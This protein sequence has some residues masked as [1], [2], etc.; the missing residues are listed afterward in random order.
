[1]IKCSCYRRTMTKCAREK[2][3][4]KTLRSV[5][6][7]DSHSFLHNEE[8]S[9]GERGKGKGKKGSPSTCVSVLE[10][11][12]W[13]NHTPCYLLIIGQWSLIMT[14][15]LQ[16]TVFHWTSFVGTNIWH[17][18]SVQL[19]ATAHLQTRS[20]LSILCCVCACRLIGNHRLL[21]D[22][23]RSNR[24]SMSMNMCS[25]ECSCDKLGRT[26]DRV[27]AASLVIVEVV[28]SG[29]STNRKAYIQVTRCNLWAKY[30]V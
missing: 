26:V 20:K 29:Q 25:S 18:S 9:K 28:V 17:V 27:M 22:K 2:V 15:I 4:A 24:K 14:H 11:A 12:E 10:H 19:T 3:S 30:N 8:E 23:Q 1:M 5:L 21:K 7:G 16:R 6:A 13:H